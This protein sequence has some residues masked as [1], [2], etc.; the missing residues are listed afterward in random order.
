MSAL[1]ELREHLREAARRDIEAERARVRRVRRRSTAFLAAVLLG[2]AAAA[3][4]ADLISVGEPVPDKRQ[5]FDQYRAAEGGGMTPVVT[6]A[7]GSKYP[8]GVAIYT[9]KNGQ[10]CAVAGEARGSSL[11]RVRG[12]TFRPY[13]ATQSG[14]C[15]SARTLFHSAIDIGDRT[16][17]FGR[18]KPG[19][20]T[21]T[22]EGT[23]QPVGRGGA[24]LFVMKRVPPDYP[25]V[26]E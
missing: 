10:R 19:A 6:A 15:G 7:S 3:T 26:V 25:F 4:A 2:G 13:D 17:L 22:F 24:F 20:K 23:T 21:V 14:A 12:N 16:L 9:A 5:G 18:S 11:G 8:F 1:S